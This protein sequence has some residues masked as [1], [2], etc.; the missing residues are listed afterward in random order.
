M[1]TCPVC[2]GRLRCIE[3]R[4]NQNYTVRRRRQCDEC[5]HRFTTREQIVPTKSKRAKYEYKEPIV[6]RGI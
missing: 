2:G 5:G 4:E 1:I 6:Q 3:R